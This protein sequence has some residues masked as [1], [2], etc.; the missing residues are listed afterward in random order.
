MGRQAW[1]YVMLAAA[2]GAVGVGMQL[3]PHLPG[4]WGQNVMSY[5]STDLGSWA[6]ITVVIATYA[7][8][9]LHAGG[10][11]FAFMMAMVAGYYLLYPVSAAWN[12]RWFALAVLMFPIGMVVFLYRDRL[13]VFVALEV[14]MAVFLAYDVFVL[15]SKV[16]GGEM[17]V[18]NELGESVIVR[19]TA[20]SLGNYVLLP[21]AV[22]WCMWFMWRRRRDRVRAPAAGRSDGE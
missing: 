16:A 18:Y 6:V 14:A 19:E 7:P 8:G 15:A 4:Q 1:R 11:C 12:L 5:M 22:I 9:M 20:F 13:W 21:L 2:G 10:R 17:I 3:L